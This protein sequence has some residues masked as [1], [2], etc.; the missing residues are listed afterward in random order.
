MRQSIPPTR[1]LARMVR[2]LCGHLARLDPADLAALRA[3]AR[4]RSA[5]EDGPAGLAAE[6]LRKARYLE[7]LLVNLTS[8]GVD[9]VAGAT[10]VTRHHADKYAAALATP[11]PMAQVAHRLVYHPAE[12]G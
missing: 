7:E 3:S 12:A 1:E 5:L 11:D 2:E 6:P 10:A 8:L 9:R 4:K